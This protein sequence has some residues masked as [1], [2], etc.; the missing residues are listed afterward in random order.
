MIKPA[1]ITPSR[2][3]DD[4]CRAR[5]KYASAL[6]P[7]AHIH[8]S[9]VCGS[10]TSAV[11]AL[12]KK[13]GFYVS[14][15]D[16]AFY[17]P[18][19]AVVR[20]LAD[21][22]DEGY[23]PENLTPAPELVV[24]GNA[25]SRGNPEVEAVLAQGIPFASMPEVFAAQLI[26]ERDYCRTSVVVAGT[27]GKTTTTAAIAYLLDAT[28]RKP[29]YFIGGVPENLAG[30]IRPVSEEIP[31]EQR[32]VVLEGD[33][34]DSAFFAKY[35]KFHC[36]RP[37]IAV[38]TSL[39]FDHGDI[40]NSVEEIEQEFTRFAARLPEE[41][42]I[43]VCDQGE[44]LQRLA[45]TWSKDKAIKA[46]ILRYGMEAATR[47]RLCSRSLWCYQDVPRKRF[48]QKLELGIGEQELTVRTTLSGEH[49]ALNL[50][51]AR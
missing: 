14:G 6:K 36:Y 5:I 16:K 9:G 37:D 28:G 17:P 2:V 38:I 27:H 47:Y 15:S 31:V 32:V 33:E 1:E 30:N 42:L 46:P 49:N 7:G 11:L 29:G 22:L 3:L 34:Y 19:G 26:A 4:A 25:L 8:I 24:I 39:E 13:R 23:R 51:A 43:L 21:R 35:A 50:L 18:M 10:G 41:G 44:R 40:Y 20:G 48:G 12:L 45:E